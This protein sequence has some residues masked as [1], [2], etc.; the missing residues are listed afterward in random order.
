MT[1]AGVTTQALRVRTV[2]AVH[3]PSRRPT[4][5]YNVAGL[6]RATGRGLVQVLAG[7]GPAPA[8]RSRG[9]R[10][11]AT[12]LTALGVA[13]AVVAAA[14]LVIA[15]NHPRPPR[16]SSALEL[17]VAL[18]PLLLAARRPLL[19]WRAAYLVALFVPFVP[20]EPRVA[21]LQAAVL[22]VLFCVAGL[23]QERS[24]LWWMWALMLVPI[25]VWVGPGWEKPAVISVC[26]TAVTFALDAIAT[27]RR[28]H[29]ALVRQAEHT[30]LEMAR[31]AVLEERARIA[32]E[33]HDVVAHHMSMIAVQA[34]TAPYRLDDLTEPALA[35][36]AA[37]SRV[38]RGALVDMRKLLGVLRSD[39]P[40]ERAPQPQLSDV[41]ELVE[42]TRRAGMAIELS[43]PDSDGHVPPTVGLCAY[44]IVQ[45]A[46]SN[47]GRHAPRA[48]IAVRVEQNDRSVRVAVF[49]SPA[50]SAVAG[51]GA[52]R[53]G[54][55]LVGMRERVALLGGSLS[56]G[57]DQ[58]GGFAVS[59]VLPIGQWPRPGSR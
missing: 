32:R 53:S 52:N 19:A 33:M 41:P 25:W 42:A 3:L 35:E 21:A 6:L 45:E 30:E 20:G 31:R 55:G 7:P 9:H 46:L 39:T 49:N 12:A 26:L 17:S 50:T 59:A 27:S 54:H 51:T 13:L 43:M 4:G 1:V 38:A 5:S 36:F 44:R 8:W 24:V 48:R 37:L 40:A 16:P 10:W 22:V 47:V 57:P 29:E 34:E 2:R 58:V 28:A 23:R 11:G 56:A 18:V 15:L 14:A